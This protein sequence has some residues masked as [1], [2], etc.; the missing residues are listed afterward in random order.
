MHCFQKKKRCTPGLP[1]GGHAC[2]SL[3]WYDNDLGTFLRR[4]THFTIRP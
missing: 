3:F 2:P 1:L 4:V